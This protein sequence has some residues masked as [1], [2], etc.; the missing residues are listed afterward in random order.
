M[1]GKNIT[2]S[3]NEK[4]SFISNMATMYNAGIPILE[5]IESMA[6]DS[7]GSG[8]KILD[9]IHDDLIQGQSL[10]TAFSKFPKVFNNVTVNV[11]KASEEAGTLD[12]VLKDIKVQIQKDME[13]TDSVKSALTYPVII[14]ILFLM[15]MLMILVV[16]VPKIG[17]VFVSLKV[18]LPLPTKIMIFV[19][20]LII[21]NTVI[22][23]LV[24]IALFAI[25]I[26]T[27]KAKKEIV[28]N[29][30]FSLPVV[31][32]LV[33]EIDIARFSRSMYLLLTS[34][35]TITNALNLAKDTVLRKDVASVIGYAEQTILSGKKL[36]DGF[37]D[38]K[39]LF[40]SLIIKII[41]AG[42]KTGTLDKS[43]EEISNYMDYQVSSS[44]KKLVSLMEPLMLVFVGALVGGMMFSIIAPIYGLISQVGGG[45][46]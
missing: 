25:V 40:P 29:L 36:S 22:V 44:L 20:D 6:E 10:S 3:N 19:S 42:E 15:V 12:I 1:T 13:F 41:E 9:S 11:I 18:A 43:M 30:V 4:L 17:S 26:V 37:K 46:K 35:I 31:S 34:G 39:S 2:I 14:L 16:V 5:T 45:G 7:K 28:L 8:K 32:K 24:T 23:A 27:Y 21:H 38:K 33:R